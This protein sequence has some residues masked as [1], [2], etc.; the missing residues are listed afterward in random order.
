MRA[1]V[2]GLFVLSILVLYSSASAR[3]LRIGHYRAIVLLGEP[4]LLPDVQ[5]VSFAGDYGFSRRLPSTEAIERHIAQESALHSNF[6]LKVIN[7]EFMLPGSSKRELDRQIDKV[8][9]D[10][11]KRT[12]YNLVSRANNHAMDYGREGVTYNTGLLQ[13]AGLKMIGTREFPVYNWETGAGKIAIFSLTDYTDRPDPD[14]LILKINEADLDL[15]KKESSKADFRIA[16][17]HLGSMSPYPSP[18]ERTQVERILEAGADLVV[19]AGSHFSKG[20]VYERGKPVIYDIGNHLLSYV[21]HVTEPVGIYFVAGFRT[22]KLV[23]LVVI[24]FHNEI[25]SGKIGPLDDTDLASFQKTLL[26]RSTSD[27]NKYFSDPSSLIRLQQ[28]LNRFSFS[29]LNELRG[30]H[31]LYA[32]SVLYNHYPV[33]VIGSG[34]LTVTLTILFVRWTLL[35]Q[36]KRKREI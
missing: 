3:E 6:Q 33:I 35:R 24:P 11:M 32:A 17:A 29:K 30:R 12:G 13:D 15:I 25:F 16:F 2:L 34:L 1:R 9:I 14:G 21:D 28:G 5:Y 26:D 23:Q 31:I 10:L 19:C 22:K 36:K 27:P 20:F 7:L 8:T 4:R 18:H